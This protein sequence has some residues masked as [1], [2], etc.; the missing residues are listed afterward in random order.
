M[1]CFVNLASMERII[2]AIFHRFNQ[3]WKNHTL[4]S[5]THAA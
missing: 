1:V 4:R 2:F 3:D 5:F